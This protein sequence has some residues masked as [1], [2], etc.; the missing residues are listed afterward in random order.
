MRQIT[1]MKRD[2]KKVIR[3][4]DGVVEAL[5]VSRGKRDCLSI[6]LQGPS[7]THK[8]SSYQLICT[9][10]VSRKIRIIAEATSCSV[11]DDD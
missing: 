9:R 7:I 1:R 10:A 11:A 2:K 4:S 5:L 6:A 3:H 8:D